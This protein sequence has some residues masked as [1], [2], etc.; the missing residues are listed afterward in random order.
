MGVLECG[1]GMWGR[2]GMTLAVLL[3]RSESA[4]YRALREGREAVRLLRAWSLGVCGESGAFS[5]FGWCAAGVPLALLA[6][7]LGE[8]RLPCCAHCR[9]AGRALRRWATGPWA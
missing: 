2:E 6:P 3:R 1:L 4:G 5:G 7:A 9:K 8:R